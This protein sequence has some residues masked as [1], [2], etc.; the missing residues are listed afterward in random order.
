MKL[1]F[2]HPVK[3]K[4]KGQTNCKPQLKFIQILKAPKGWFILR[5]I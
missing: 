5:Y 2:A 3:A 4:V 1:K